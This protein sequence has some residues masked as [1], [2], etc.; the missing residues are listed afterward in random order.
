MEGRGIGVLTPCTRSSCL[1]RQ[2]SELSEVDN[3]LLCRVSAAAF[4]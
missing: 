1:G 2:Q 4:P 3:L